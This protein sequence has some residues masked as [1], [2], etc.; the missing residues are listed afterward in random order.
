MNVVDSSGWLEYLA[1]AGNASFF[2]SA[3]LATD[4]LIVPVVCLYEVFKR[5]ALQRGE[6]DA[7]QAVGVLYTGEIVDLTAEI[8]LEAANLSIEHHLPM[9]DS[10][11]LAT[12]HLYNATLWTQ[13]E[14]FKGIPDVKYIP[15]K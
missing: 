2:E 11:I 1:D 6:Q 9:A 8:A 14:D 3:I 12:S 13:D 5:I 10:L 4:Q 7:L 15:K